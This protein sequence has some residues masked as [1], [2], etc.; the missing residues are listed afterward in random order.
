MAKRLSADQRQSAAEKFM[1][2]GNL[3]FAGLV[4]AQVLSQD[5]FDFRVAVLGTVLF[6]FAYGMA[7]RYMRGGE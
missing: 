1:E 5:A 4:I 6:A 2:W 3:V 7:F